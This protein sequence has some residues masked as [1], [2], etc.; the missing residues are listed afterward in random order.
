MVAGLDGIA[1]H[2]AISLSKP[3]I[4]DTRALGTDLNPAG[5]R[6][7]RCE[8]LAPNIGVVLKEPTI[9]YEAQHKTVSSCNLSNDNDF[10]TSRGLWRKRSL[11]TG[12][13]FGFGSWPRSRARRGPLHDRRGGH[14]SG[15]W[16]HRSGP[17]R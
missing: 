10:G 4:R 8:V 14:W 15:H 16:Q 1:F 12:L 9:V 2:R 3:M 6:G 17:A 13:G 5:M 11:A 7:T